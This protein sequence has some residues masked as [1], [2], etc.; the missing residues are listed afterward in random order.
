VWSRAELKEVAA[1][2]A[3]QGAL[4]VADEIW[5]DWVLPAAAPAERGEGGE[6][7][8]RFVPCSSVA[9]AEGCA[10]IT[11]GAPTKSWSLAGL[12]ASYLIIPDEA[13]RRR[14]L[15]AHA[16]AT[17]YSLLTAHYSL[18]TT[19]YSLLTTHYSLLTLTTHCSLLTA[20]CSLLT[21]HCSLLLAT[22]YLLLTTHYLQR[23]E[24]HRNPNPNQ[25]AEP[26]FLA[27][28]SAFAT[29]AILA[30]YTHGGPWLEAAKAHVARNVAYLLDFVHEHV[31][32]IVPLVRLLI[33]CAS[34]MP[35][36]DA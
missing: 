34:T 18:L 6:G 7:G 29:T 2:C 28:G 33:R 20:Y 14:Y 26:A 30:A 36:T 8:E 31:P 13:L 25:R 11:L 19:H 21:A 16:L 3:R 24:P 23:V 17:R 22:R 35:D 10:L 4:L 12:H 32:G 27:Y 5:A 9:P 1:A 15:Q